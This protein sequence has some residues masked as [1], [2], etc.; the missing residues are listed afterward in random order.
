MGINLQVPRLTELKPR[1][2]VIG[3]GGAGGNAINNMIASG[4]KG[5][6]FVSANTD[7]QALASSSAEHRI[8]LGISITEGLGAGARPEVGQAAAEEAVEEIRGH[9]T[10]AHM[11]F[12]AAGMGGG[13]GTGAASVIARIARESGALTVAIVTKPFAFEGARRMRMAELGI[14]E[15][16]GNVDTLIVIPNQNLFRIANEKTT[17]AEA[18]LLAD[19]VLH[20]GIACITDLIIR[21]GLINLDFADVRTVMSGMGTAMM[22]TGEAGGEHRA[23]QAAELAILN[24]LLDD[25]S[26]RGARG[27]LISISGNRNLTLYEVDEA[28]SRI[29]QEVDPE[30]N[31]IVGAT[32][33]EGL[34]DKLRVS[35]VASGLVGA[36]LSAEP[37]ARRPAPASMPAPQ[38]H[39]QPEPEPTPADAHHEPAAPTAQESYP[40]DP[41]PA[42][43]EAPH[44]TLEARD[45][46]PEPLDEPPS[47]GQDDDELQDG[48]VWRGPGDVVIELGPPRQSR[49]APPTRSQRDP[50]QA[51]PSRE[52]RFSPQPPVE[53]RRLPRRMPDVEDFPNVGQREYLSKRAGHVEPQAETSVDKRRPGLF[54]RLTGI[55]SDSRRPNRSPD[56]SARGANGGWPAEPDD[57]TRSRPGN[58]HDPRDE[59]G[60]GAA[61]SR[62]SSGRS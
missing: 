43:P 41:E 45:R 32:F 11:V 10:G 4:I 12:I 34:G 42:M 2:V 47:A 13:T 1:I 18:F 46:D 38:A 51:E 20:S 53:V 60:R 59:G 39:A 62:Q 6:E 21:E 33:D 15:L 26:L 56:D 36:S 50:A 25:I 9:V 37:S 31:I 22:G 49:S 17:F 54:A 58:G 8:Q 61:Y 44:W 55:G 35:I 29:R 28:A 7:A 3:V 27:L 23:V 24:P 16:N 40:V 57:R 14:N 5:V 48:E 19:Q 30:A 52:Q